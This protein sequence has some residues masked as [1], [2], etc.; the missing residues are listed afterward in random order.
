MSGSIDSSLVVSA[1]WRYPVKGLGGESLPAAEVL[2]ER[3]IDGDRRWMLAVR[4]VAGLLAGDEKWLP[5]NYAR[6]LKS[7]ARLAGLR[8]SLSKDV[9]TVAHG[10]DVVRG[11]PQEP[12]D[13]RQ[14]EEFLR[15]ALN[16]DDIFLADCQAHPA[17][18]DENTPLTVLFS[19]SVSDLSRHAGVSLSPIRFRAN[20][21]VEGGAPWN[22]RE[23]FGGVLT[24]GDALQLSIIEGVERCPA[25]QVN[26]QTG[27]R[28]CNVPEMLLR[29]FQYNEMGVKCKIL[30]G[31]KV[32]AGES[33]QWQSYDA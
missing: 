28:D 13:K 12:A 6:T 25:T 2:S 33:A 19:A 9:L 20:L 1:V 23:H 32:A 26:P 17:W 14:L 21:I 31:G 11:V 5:W 3:G 10:D 8:A 30:Q 16:D 24:V 4:D 18:D 15:G 27:E 7:S 22:E 29:H